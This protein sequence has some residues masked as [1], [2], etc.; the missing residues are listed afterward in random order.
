[1]AEIEDDYDPSIEKKEVA[2]WGGTAGA[3]HHRKKHKQDQPGQTPEDQ[4]F[5]N[6]QMGN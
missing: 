3:S 1:M 5:S 6:Q 2:G 4:T